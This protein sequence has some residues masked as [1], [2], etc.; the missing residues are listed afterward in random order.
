MSDIYNFGRD[1]LPV[2]L[3][4]RDFATRLGSGEVAPE[5]LW[6]AVVHQQPAFVTKVRLSAGVDLSALAP[7][8]ERQS[9]VGDPRPAAGELP[10]SEAGKEALFGALSESAALGDPETGPEHLLIAILREDAGWNI[11]RD[12]C[13][14][15]GLTADRIIL[16][17][18]HT[19]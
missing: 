4:A 19:E 16:A 17:L 12:V 11:A 2:V 1:V 15:A 7:E 6:L 9:T 3:L 14:K 8:V 13:L 18:K 5:H 10:Y